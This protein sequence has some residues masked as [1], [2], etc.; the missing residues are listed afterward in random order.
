MYLSAAVI[1]PIYL[2]TWCVLALIITNLHVCKEAQQSSACIHCF[3]GYSTGDSESIFWPRHTI[4]SVK[5]C[6][7]ISAVPLCRCDDPWE[8]MQPVI[9]IAEHMM[10]YGCIYIISSHTQRRVG[11]C[12]ECMLVT[13][14][15]SLSVY[16]RELRLPWLTLANP[17]TQAS[18]T[19]WLA[20]T[21]LVTV[22]LT[23]H[24]L[25]LTY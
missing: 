13:D 7:W 1:L 15:V 3:T 22:L 23:S 25:T 5:Q 2:L 4:V 9:L 19:S 18:L 20:S 11:S 6:M 16:M 21:S 8:S 24:W 12:Q 14:S 17:T 10:N